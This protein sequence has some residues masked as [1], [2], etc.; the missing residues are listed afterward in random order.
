MLRW[1]YRWILVTGTAL[2]L[3]ACATPPKQAQQVATTAPDGEKLICVRSV[4]TGYHIPQR[5]CYTKA[6]AEARKKADQTAMQNL[7]N[8][9]QTLHPPGGPPN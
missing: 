6:Q 5:S 4:E 7:Q 2:F 8:N 3:T 1:M 9:G